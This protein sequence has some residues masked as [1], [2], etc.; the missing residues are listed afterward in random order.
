MIGEP[1]DEGVLTPCGRLA[2]GLPVDLTLGRMIAFG[3]QIGI[4]EEAV[5]LAAALSLP[6]SPYRI[7]TPIVHSNPDEY[8]EIVQI[9]MTSMM[10]IDNGIF[11]EPIMLCELLKTWRN[12]H[13]DKR[14]SWLRKN[15]I[16]KS[17][18]QQFNATYQ[19]ILER[20]QARAGVSKHDEK[21]KLSPMQTLNFMRLLLTWVGENNVMTMKPHKVIQPPNCIGVTSEGITKRHLEPLIPKEY[22]WSL[23][24]RGSRMYDI[25]RTSA[26]ILTAKSFID[27][28]IDIITM[29]SVQ[30]VSLVWI[31][32]QANCAPIEGH[33]ESFILLSILESDESMLSTV[34]EIFRISQLDSI[35]FETDLGYMTYIVINPS[36][37]QYNNIKKIQDVPKGSIGVILAAQGHVKLNILNFTLNEDKIFDVFDLNDQNDEIAVQ[38]GK[39]SCVIRFE[40]VPPIE[41]YNPLFENIHPCVQLFNA[42]RFGYK[43]RCIY[44]VFIIVFFI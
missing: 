44:D 32:S 19:N 26:D 11:S 17:R 14:E 4:C 24:V 21:M 29:A 12:M 31:M 3:I 6:R 20:V 5:M 40:D 8:N 38:D 13:G 28:S 36:K 10:K 7:A 2:G 22:K 30:Q 25:P 27:F 35:D 33:E 39:M 41:N 42:Y 37:K 34:D 16:V 9:T 23:D 1:N 43:D 15:G 18:I